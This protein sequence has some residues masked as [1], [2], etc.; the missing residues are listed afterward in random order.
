[1][2][3]S[4]GYGWNSPPC[5]CAPGF[6]PRPYHLYYQAPADIDWSTRGMIFCF[7]LANFYEDDA[8]SGA[9]YLHG[10]TLERV[11]TD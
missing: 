9:L 2:I 5:N 4:I 3:E 1:V 7:D 6:T 10:L 11:V 8:P